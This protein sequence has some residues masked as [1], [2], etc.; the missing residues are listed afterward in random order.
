M[1]RQVADP[2]DADTRLCDGVIVLHRAAAHADCSD[3][4]AFLVDNWEATW[5]SDQ[6]VI[7]MLD[8]KQGAPRL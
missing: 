8:P 3:Q 7:G 1:C 4:N 6:A 5:K 2:N